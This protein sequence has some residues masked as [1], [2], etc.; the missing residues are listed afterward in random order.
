MVQRMLGFMSEIV[1][2]TDIYIEKYIGTSS[3]F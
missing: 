1:S 3:L 2:S